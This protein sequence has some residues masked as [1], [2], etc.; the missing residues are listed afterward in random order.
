M[1]AIT[2]GALEACSAD[3]RPLRI[4][5]PGTWLHYV[6]DGKGYYNGRELGKGEGFI[7]YKDTPCEY[8]PDKQTPW[9]YLWVR[10]GGIDEEGLLSACGFPSESGVFSFEYG[11]TLPMLSSLFFPKG[12]YPDP[13]PLCRE[14]YA[15]LLLSLHA[16]KREEDKKE[17][18]WIKKAKEYVAANYH[19]P[20]RVEEMAAA[21]HIDRKYL[22]NL[23][24]R[25]LGTST[26]AYITGYR[27][28]R[29]AELLAMEG[30]SVSLAAA[31]VGYED[32]FGFS[33]T[34]KKHFGMS[35]SAYREKQK[36]E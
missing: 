31:S 14:A 23:F 11:D 18:L 21:L 29:A 3:K 33:K 36:G 8:Y 20:F 6:L 9:A 24:T 13:R 26:M 2:M 7:T 30:V 4:I 12:V 22:R 1:L 10:L 25:H 16:E 32:P 35:P 17:V 15:K 5:C 28:A 34:F 27:M 19:K